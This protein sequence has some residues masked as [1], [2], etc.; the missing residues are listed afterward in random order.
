MKG[1]H[2]DENLVRR[3]AEAH[4]KATVA[5][6]LKTAA[7]DLTPE[8]MA[9]AGAVMGQMPKQ[10]TGCEIVAIEAEGE[11]CVAQILYKGDDKA[12]TVRSVW[13]DRDGRPKIVEL[14]VN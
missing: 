5:G 1:D 2:V 9:Q 7:G 3:H 14:T 11:S 6:D 4:G 8:A 13:A 12:V 10:L